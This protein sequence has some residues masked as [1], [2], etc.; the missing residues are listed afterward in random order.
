M[1]NNISKGK[2]T[3]GITAGL[4]FIF[5]QGVFHYIFVMALLCF[6]LYLIINK[7]LDSQD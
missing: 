2:L 6:P 5:N 3:A 7:W 1:F 4:F